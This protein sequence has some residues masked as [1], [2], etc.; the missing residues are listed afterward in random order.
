[1][2][3]SKTGGTG[4]FGVRANIDHRAERNRVNRE[5]TPNR[6][7]FSLLHE[8][9]HLM[10][11]QSGAS[12]LNV[13]AARPP[14]TQHVEVFCNADA[15]AALVPRERLLSQEIVQHY[16]ARS[17][18]WNDD[19]LLELA[20]L[21]AVRRIALLRRLREGIMRR[22]VFY[23]NLQYFCSIPNYPADTNG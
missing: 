14:E 3:Q 1:M 9:A 15:A 21:F 17:V 20:N 10:L 11:G 18:Q 4:G 22:C 16:G 8:F 6:R 7:A 5:D 12:D 23:C 13:D 2:R 19:D